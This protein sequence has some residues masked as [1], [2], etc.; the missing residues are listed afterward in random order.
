MLNKIILKGNIG[1]PPHVA[2]TQDGREVASFDLATHT[3]WRDDQGEWQTITEWHHIKVFKPST[4]RWS[5]NVLKQGDTVYVEGKLSYH[6]GVDKWG[7]PRKTA[8]I[9]VSQ[10]GGKVEYLRSPSSS[11]NKVNT[12]SLESQIVSPFEEES[13]ETFQEEDLEREAQ[14]ISPFHL[15]LSQ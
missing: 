8:Q 1:R 13:P 15:T 2:L 5:K 6:H 14:A 12:P 7:Q 4:V 3:S 10:F 11:Q 9:V